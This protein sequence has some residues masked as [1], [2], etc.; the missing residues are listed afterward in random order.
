MT[1]TPNRRWLRFSL[2]TLFVVVTVLVCWLGCELNWIRQRHRAIGSGRID[3]GDEF[4]AF[5]GWPLLVDAPGILGL[6]GERGYGILLFEVSSPDLKL[7]QS[8]TIEL[9][10]LRQLFPEAQIDLTWTEPQS[11]SPPSRVKQ[12]TG[13]AYDGFKM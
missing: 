12:S 10:H 9:D 11:A 5:T 6:F 3:S 13:S 4:Y 7:T 2:R 8:E 1:P